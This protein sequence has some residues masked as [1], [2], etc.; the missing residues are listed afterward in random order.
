MAT[1]SYPVMSDKYGSP[2]KSNDL[3]FSPSDRRP[4]TAKLIANLRANFSPTLDAYSRTTTQKYTSA[5]NME[6][7]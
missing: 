3:L 5:D 2:R 4:T 6:R 7:T 1:A